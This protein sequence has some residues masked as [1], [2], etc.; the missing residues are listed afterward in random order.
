MTDP[1]DP[2]LIAFYLPQFHPIPE[3]DRWWGR[4]FTEWTNL[5]RAQPL[6]PGH[7]Q[8]RL[9]TDLGFYD[10]RLPDTRV[11]QAALARQAGIH[12]FCYYHYWFAGQ[13]LLQRP[14]DEMVALGQPDFPFCVCWANES[15][16]RRWDGLEREILM[17]QRYEG[18]NP[19]AFLRDL[20]PALRDPRYIRI[21]GRAL[22]LVYRP[23]SIPDI[24]RW[25]DCWRRMAKAEGVGDLY[26]CRVQSFSQDAPESIG[27]DAAVEF[28]PLGGF[29]ERSLLSPTDTAALLGHDS[30]FQGMLA[31]YSRFT[32]L[33]AEAPAPPFR[34]FRGVFPSWDNTPRRKQRA[35]I[36]NGANPVDYED[37]LTAALQHTVKEQHG[38]ERLVFINAWNEW[39][40]GCHLEPD[41]YF[42]DRYL[43]ATRSALT[44][45][46]KLHRPAGTA[47]E[48]GDV[49]PLLELLDSRERSV[50]ALAAE[51]RGREATILELRG[52][53]DVAQKAAREAAAAMAAGPAPR[54]SG[55]GLA[56]LAAGGQRAKAVI[57]GAGRG[58]ERALRHLL[59]NWEI[60]AF[61]DNDAKKQGTQL[62]G[63]P[64]L[65]PPELA[66]YGE[67]PVWVASM[68]GTEIQK[69][70]LALGVSRSRI[71]HLDVQVLAGAAPA[72]E[73][74]RRLEVI[75]FGTGQGGLRA[76][77]NLPPECRAIAFA[78]NDPAKA[79]REFCGLP[80]LR[81]VELLDRSFDHVLVASMY[82]DVIIPQLEKLGVPSQKIEVVHR[83]I[84]VG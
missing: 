58:G 2:R 13:R 16:T 51:V 40:E 19:E 55:Q 31:D 20:L 70:L 9:P 79:G 61:L 67:I 38:E 66:R 5:T 14:F 59:A 18:V 64:I 8:P 43:R 24:A 27:F 3:N 75:I 29:L 65:S 32:K 60:V 72:P 17:A 45:A 69:Q 33:A 26:L 10:L 30:T 57:F 25:A 28:P 47:A 35:L 7:V 15:W 53:L 62:A 49:G 76:F 54:A 84:L 46:V 50:R 23:E 37:W 80:I 78:D 73:A 21:N 52:A 41:A 34:R 22:L 11:A 44:T 42:D 74:G 83:D 39:A 77:Q 4:G 1:I 56:A 68:Y 81:P 12:G 63:L 82:G 36:F 6:F 48:R 71:H